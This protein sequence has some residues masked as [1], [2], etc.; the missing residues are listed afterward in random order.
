MRV[1][2]DAWPQGERQ[3]LKNSVERQDAP[4]TVEDSTATSDSV[5]TPIQRSQAFVQDLG[6]QATVQIPACRL[7]AMLSL[8]QKLFTRS[9]PQFK[10]HK[11]KCRLRSAPRAIQCERALSSVPLL[12]S[13]SELTRPTMLARKS[14]GPTTSLPQKMPKRESADGASY[15][16]AVPAG[17]KDHLMPPQLR[18]RMVSFCPFALVRQ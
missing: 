17:G 4:G 11:L 15:L 6:S 14:R 1:R 5:R 8:A 3:R 10:T 16:V 12:L 9:N 7:G 2:N 13:W 18:L